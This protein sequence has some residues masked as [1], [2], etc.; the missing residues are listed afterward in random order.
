MKSSMTFTGKAAQNLFKALISQQ[1]QENT[2]TD[3]THDGYMQNAQ[4]HLIPREQV[5]DIDIA[6]DEFVR[7]KVAKII[8]M[9]RLLGNLKLE[10]LDDMAAFVQLSAERYGVKIGG[11]KGNI[12]MET[13]DGALRLKRQMSENM[14]FDEGLQ[15][16]KA[17]I[18]ECLREWCEKSPGELRSII[19]Q[20]FRVDREG[21]INTAAILGLRRLKIEDERWMRAMQAI[22]DS[23]TITDTKAYVRAYRRDAKGKYS[24]ISLDIAAL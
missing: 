5:R 18:D 11:D 8:E 15:A 9:Q 10:L 16:A 13:F 12:T 6:R 2:M 14:A 17:L 20:A 3:K 24:P 1:E 22:G 7:E 4:G 21:R 23:L 19:D